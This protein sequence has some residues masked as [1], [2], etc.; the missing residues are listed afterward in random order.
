MIEQPVTAIEGQ[1]A[2]ARLNP[3][4]RTPLKPVTIPKSCIIQN[5]QESSR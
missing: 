1:A 2:L 4:K 3:N 5:V